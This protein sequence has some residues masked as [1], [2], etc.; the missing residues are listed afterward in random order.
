MR[1]QKELA[2]D[3]SLEEWKARQRIDWA[4]RFRQHYRAVAESAGG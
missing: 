2:K 3:P 4:Q 1:K